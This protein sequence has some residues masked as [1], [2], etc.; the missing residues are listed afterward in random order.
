MCK[1]KSNVV[2][3]TVPRCFWV[4]SGLTKFWL[5]SNDT[6]II[7]ITFVLKIYLLKWPFKLVVVELIFWTIEKIGVW[8]PNNLGFQ[9]KSS[10][11]SL[12]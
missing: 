4:E 8:F 3:N 9:V 10:D 7:L 2:P 5:K 6:R 11:K 12:I 1:L